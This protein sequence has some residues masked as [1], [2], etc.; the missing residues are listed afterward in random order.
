M[1]LLLESGAHCR[2][3][4]DFLEGAWLSFRMPIGMVPLRICKACGV[5]RTNKVE[6]S[7][8]WGEIGL[9]VLFSDIMLPNTHTVYLNENIIL[10][11]T[12]SV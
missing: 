12:L 10:S 5:E 11:A 3:Q 7:E 1:L 2:A 8:L 9:L 4:I 6:S